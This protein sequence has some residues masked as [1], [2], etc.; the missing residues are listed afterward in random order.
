MSAAHDTFQQ[1]TIALSKQQALIRVTSN[2]SSIVSEY[3][4]QK[5]RTSIGRGSS[6]D[7][8]INE[9]LVSEYHFQIEQHDGQ[10]YLMHPHPARAIW[11]T[12]NGFSYQGKQ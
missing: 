12:R 4:I 9:D 1:P 7:I 3:K 10:Y 2:N 5:Y 11:G 6:C 8:P